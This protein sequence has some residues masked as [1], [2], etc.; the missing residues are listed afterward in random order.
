MTFLVVLIITLP[1]PDGDQLTNNAIIINEFMAHP[2]ASTTQAEGEWIELYNKS[3]DW[4]NLSGWILTNETGQTVNLCSYLLPPGE[5]MVLGSSGDPE[6]NGGYTPDIVYSDFTLHDIDRITLSSSPGGTVQDLVDYDY[7][8]A[9]S[10]GK[11]C[12]KYNPDWVS[13]LSSSW[14]FSES[15]FGYGDFGTP[16][17]Q[18]SIFQGSFAENTWAFIKAFVQ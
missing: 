8:W 2:L 1:V 3:S 18:N 17:D 5:C 16:G 11:S 15:I 13:N 14:N 4:V 7:T 12:E 10:P 6:R 9:I